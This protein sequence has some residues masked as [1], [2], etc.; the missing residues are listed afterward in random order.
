[1]RLPAPLAHAIENELS[2]FDRK[3]LARAVEELSASY[4]TPP[5]DAHLSA[6][7]INNDVQRAA[8][9]LTRVPATFAAIYAVLREVKERIPELEVRSL[10]DLGA[11][12]GT[13]MWAAAE[14]FSELEQVT[15]I[16]RS[17]SFIRLGQK[18]ASAAPA[19]M[20]NARWVEADLERERQLP[21]ND[22]VI[23]SYA[24]GELAP[25]RLPCAREQGDTARLS[26]GT[27]SPR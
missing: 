16:E 19:T 10:L 25:G 18:L 3:A 15:L 23:V 4:R 5:K 12:P 20:Q 11:G 17:S 6:S 9:L 7:F 8:Y 26:G 22:L 21:T 2:Q 13:A 27:R 1:M 14:I 24:L